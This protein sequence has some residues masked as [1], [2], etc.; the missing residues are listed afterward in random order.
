MKKVLIAALLESR[1][2]GTNF[3]HISGGINAS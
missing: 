2:L 3:K 1:D